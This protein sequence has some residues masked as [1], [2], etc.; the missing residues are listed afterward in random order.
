MLNALIFDLDGVIVDTEPM[1]FESDRMTAS[2]YG[3]RMPDELFAAYIGVSSPDMWAELIDH[4]GIPDTVENVVARLNAHKDELLA[5]MEL[6]PIPGIRELLAEA[7]G[8][9]MKIGLASSSPRR[10]IEAML[11][12]LGITDCFGAV[13]SGQEVERGKPAPDVFLRAAE[14]LGVAPGDC[15]V[16]EDACQGVRAAK[17]AGMRCIGFANPMSG[18][19]DLSLADE[20][21][22][23][24]GEIDLEKY[25]L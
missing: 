12:N 15:L 2:D 5:E 19:Q 13:V 21:V 16:I 3:F 8:A 9:G 10:F 7:A 14:L 20:I 18:G 23:T 24:I 22:G 1:H 17:A 25:L 11:D 4:Y 6:A